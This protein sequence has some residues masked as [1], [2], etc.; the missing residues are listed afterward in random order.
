MVGITPFTSG[1]D[2]PGCFTGELRAPDPG[3]HVAVVVVRGAHRCVD[4]G[5][6]HLGVVFYG[7]E[8]VMWTCL[9]EPELVRFEIWCASSFAGVQP[10]MVTAPVPAINCPPSIAV[11]PL[12]IEQMRTE[13]TQLGPA[14][15][16]QMSPARPAA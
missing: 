11:R 2:G 14:W 10:F 15:L 7:A 9:L 13:L 4:P 1:G 8:P 6:E 5:A 12:A 3:V 16:A